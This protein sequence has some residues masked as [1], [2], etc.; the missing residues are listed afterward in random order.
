MQS[1]NICSY[2]MMQHKTEFSNPVQQLTYLAAINAF[3]SHT[4]TLKGQG[5]LNHQLFTYYKGIRD[6]SINYIQGG[7]CVNNT[8]GL[9]GEP[10][11]AVAGV[12]NSW[13]GIWNGMVTVLIQLAQVRIVQSGLSQLPTMTLGL[14][15]GRGY[16]RQSQQLQEQH[17]LLYHLSWAYSIC[18]LFAPQLHQCRS[19]VSHLVLYFLFSSIVC[20]IFRGSLREHDGAIP[21]RSNQLHSKNTMVPYQLPLRFTSVTAEKYTCINFSIA[22]F[23]I[24]QITNVLTVQ[25]T[26]TYIHTYIRTYIQI[27][28]A[29]NTLMW[30]SLR[31][32]PISPQSQNI[33][34]L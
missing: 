14:F 13:T 21:T 28:L 11:Q 33:T 26:N 25:H 19:A 29:F 16:R 5:W 15:S 17:A 9:W 34:I 6:F 4:V 20:G 10:E 1:K 3:S 7:K 2:A 12:S 22:T 27:P 31:L 32:T 30:G 23:V 24:Q 18:V 8:I